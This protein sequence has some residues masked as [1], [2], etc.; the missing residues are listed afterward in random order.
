MQICPSDG[1]GTVTQ[2][3]PRLCEATSVT[4]VAEFESIR[5]SFLC[6]LKP[7]VCRGCIVMYA[8]KQGLLTMAAQKTLSVL[9]HMLSHIDSTLDV[10]LHGSCLCSQRTRAKSSAQHESCKSACECAARGIVKFKS[11]PRDTQRQCSSTCKSTEH[12]QLMDTMG[13]PRQ[14]RFASC[15]VHTQHCTAPRCYIHTAW[16]LRGYLP[17]SSPVRNIP[18]PQQL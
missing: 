11:S 2:N 7:C 13:T 6:R 9:K 12:I 5:P 1:Q 4:K 18:S 16:K 17:C 10:R 14:W 3:A 8:G 15:P